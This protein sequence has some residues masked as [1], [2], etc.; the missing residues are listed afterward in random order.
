MAFLFFLRRIF[1]VAYL[2]QHPAVPTRLK[3]LPIIAFT[4]LIFPRDLIVDLRPF[5]LLDDLVVVSILLGIFIHKGWAYVANYNEKRE[6][7]IDADFQVLMREEGRPS[8][9]Q[10]HA[11]T[12]PA[13]DALDPPGATRAP[14]DGPIDDTP[15]ED[16]RSHAD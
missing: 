8:R 15:H 6:D 16:L 9:A 10:P 5:G 3:A 1:S 11:D 2:M 14:G 13:G 4:Y 12:A 7:S